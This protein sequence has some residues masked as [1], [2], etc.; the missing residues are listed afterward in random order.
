MTVKCVVHEGVLRRVQALD[1]A[2]CGS[3]EPDRKS[4]AASHTTSVS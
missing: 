3:Y 4:E 1:E 2:I